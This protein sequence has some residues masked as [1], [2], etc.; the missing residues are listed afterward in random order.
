MWR[1][2]VP[3][4]RAVE[5]GQR[6]GRGGEMSQAAKKVKADRE[7]R[8]R[9]STWFARTEGEM[10]LGWGKIYSDEFPKYAKS[11]GDA[12]RKEIGEG[13][14]WVEKNSDGWWCASFNTEIRGGESG[15]T[16]AEAAAN[17]IR[18]KLREIEKDAAAKVVTA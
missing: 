5:D 12:L 18:A 3:R 13:A 1:W 9:A 16:R 11:L 2:P 15:K 4:G 17:L 10:K 7:D 14:I 6:A 8:S